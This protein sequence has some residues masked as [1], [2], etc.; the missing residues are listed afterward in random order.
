M[1]KT[2]DE[3]LGAR[4]TLYIPVVC[5][6]SEMVNG[7]EQSRTSFGIPCRTKQAA[8]AAARE[9]CD[10]MGGICFTVRRADPMAEVDHG[11]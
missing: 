5:G 8:W 11:N 4:E 2:L 10:Q 7:I 9:M 3:I 6:A 1:D